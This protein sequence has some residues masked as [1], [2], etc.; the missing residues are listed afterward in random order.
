MR[1]RLEASSTKKDPFFQTLEK[2]FLPKRAG[3]S[4]YVFFINKKPNGFL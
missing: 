1:T 4:F 2:P 3:R